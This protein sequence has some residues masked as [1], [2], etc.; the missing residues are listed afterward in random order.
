[1]ENKKNIYFLSYLICIAILQLFYF[2]NSS[3]TSLNILIFIVASL[4]LIIETLK[5][6][7]IE[8]IYNIGTLIILSI[9]ES[10][11]IIFE[12]RYFRENFIKP[13]YD[14]DILLYSVF[15]FLFYLILIFIMNN[16]LTSKRNIGI[17]LIF[18]IS[19]SIWVRL[20]AHFAFNYLV[21]GDSYYAYG[22][23]LLKLGSFNNLDSI[24]FINFSNATGYEVI[25]NWP[26]LLEIIYFFNKLS[27]PLDF[28]FSYFIPIFDGIL[29]PILGFLISWNFF[30]LNIDENQR[31]KLSLVS[32]I[33]LSF[34]SGIVYFSIEMSH[35]DFGIVLTL[36]IMTLLFY[37]DIYKKKY[38]LLLLFVLSL[39]ST[40]NHPILSSIDLIL[41]LVKTCLVLKDPNFGKRV[42]WIVIS[43][44]VFHLT[45]YYYFNFRAHSMKI[46]LDFFNIDLSIQYH[47]LIILLISL[48]IIS[49]FFIIYIWGEKLMLYLE[50]TFFNKNRLGLLL[51]VIFLTFSII[52]SLFFNINFFGLFSKLSIFL[53][54]IYLFTNINRKNYYEE[55]NSTHLLIVMSIISIGIIFYIFFTI[56]TNFGLG[57]IQ[58]FYTVFVILCTP[59]IS[60][61]FLNNKIKIYKKNVFAIFLISITFF[62]SYPNSMMTPFDENNPDALT[63]D[64]SIKD[65][66]LIEKFVQNFR[67]E[68]NYSKNKII[69]HYNIKSLFLKFGIPFITGEL[70]MTSLFGFSNENKTLITYEK[71]IDQLLELNVYYIILNLFYLKQSLKTSLFSNMIN[72]YNNEKFFLINGISDTLIIYEVKN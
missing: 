69:T 8:P 50:K 21:F 71:Q 10:L 39:A 26:T 43:L 68:T 52:Y 12:V 66:D 65:M 53:L 47:I 35:F 45:F 49:L 31:T 7:S 37:T 32:S 70:N 33:F 30:R 59:I 13:G 22:S 6:E 5:I 9:M 62:N 17:I 41:I 46:L 18:I 34:N 51:N 64:Y 23:L 63:L 29:I 15:I 58:R 11:N 14:F 16:S 25:S 57:L 27:F 61:I 36:S 40:A 19:L 20:I 38:L 60:S 28:F 2:K 56:W 48:S 55:F 67:L 4:S 42:K 72:F 3:N 24:D 54:L 44:L 1:M